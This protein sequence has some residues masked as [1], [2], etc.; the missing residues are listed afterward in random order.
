MFILI[1]SFAI[2]C[3]LPLEGGMLPVHE[4]TE[5]ENAIERNGLAHPELRAVIYAIRKAEN[6]GP[7]REFGILNSKADTFSKQA[8]W[9]VC[10]INKNYQR[11]IGSGCEI[12][13][14]VFL[15]NRYAPMNVANDP[16][17]LN[18]HWIKNVTIFTHKYAKEMK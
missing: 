2:I 5:I 8:G 17:L 1:V 10:T 14:I 9:C 4:V 6:G 15:G 7:G 18:E 11:W 13:Y 16:T 3:S 12:P